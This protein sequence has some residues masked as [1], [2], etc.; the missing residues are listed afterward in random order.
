MVGR[1]VEQQQVGLLPGDQRQGQARFLATGEVQ[2]RLVH[3][4]AAEVEAAEE[5]LE[6]LFALAGGD[7]LQM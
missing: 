5:V 7:T 6:G 3:P 4:N 2:Y 1:L